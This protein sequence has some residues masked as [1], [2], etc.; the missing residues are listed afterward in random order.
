MRVE[1]PLL[2]ITGEELPNGSNKQDC[3]R[4]DV[5]ALRFWLPLSLAF[6]D[7]KVTNPLA[8]TNKRMTISEMYIHHEKQKKNQYNPRIIQ[9]EKGSFTPLI[10]SCTGGAGPEAAK[11]IKELLSGR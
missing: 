1:P 6:F 10:F 5:S 3:A 4:A 7:V 9:I 11:F 2:P 8:Q